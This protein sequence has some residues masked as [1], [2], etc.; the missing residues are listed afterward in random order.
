VRLTT[1]SIPSAT[2]IKS[3]NEILLASHADMAFLSQTPSGSNL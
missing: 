2:P 3:C 1:R